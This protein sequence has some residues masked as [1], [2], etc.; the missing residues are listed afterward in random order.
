MHALSEYT[1]DASP[2][3]GMIADD[4]TGALD[5]GA[6]FVEAGFSA[7]LAFDMRRRTTRMA[8]LLV[9][10]S[11]SRNATEKAARQQ[12]ARAAKKLLRF[13]LPLVYKKIDS[14]CQGNLAAEIDAL[15]AV[16]EIDSAI[17][18]P[19]NLTQKRI[20]E[21]G[22]VKVHGEAC[23]YLP[24]LLKR[25]GCHSVSVVRTPVTQAKIARAVRYH[26]L[27]LADA[28]QQ[29]ELAC[30]AKL[31]VKSTRQILLVGSA[32][33]AAH[34]ARILAVESAKFAQPRLPTCREPR[35]SR[36]TNHAPL[37]FFIGSRNVVTLRQVDALVK[38][39]T[40][41]VCPCTRQG[42]R[43]AS[44]ALRSQIHVVVRVPIH[45]EPSTQIQSSLKYFGKVLQSCPV[46]GV[47]MSGGDTARQVCQC[48]KPHALSIHREI[49][50]GI[51]SG[52]I[53]GG[54][55]DGTNVYTKPGG[56]GDRNTLV[57]FIRAARC[58]ANTTGAKV[59][60]GI[61]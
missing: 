42:A 5:A 33:L 3:W 57:Q 46:S 52:R 29:D 43:E 35:V 28:T 27:V 49:V 18:C 48:L 60:R 22:V 34:V 53:M 50:S 26:R 24:D 58:A 47:F 15:L 23:V 8:D 31:F 1:H 9:V 38:R 45:E 12:V 56:F 59:R 11:D 14:T 19:A 6:M 25:Q 36:V 44:Q 10:S 55:A 13:D 20:V 30:L 40:T 51:S 61:V 17:I 39:V 21:N 37:V 16:L 4:L 41:K 7:N 54:L 2:S 32:G